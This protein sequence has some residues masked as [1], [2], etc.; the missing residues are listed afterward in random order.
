MF[1]ECRAFNMLSVE[2]VQILWFG[3]LPIF[4]PPP[5][6]DFTGFWKILTCF[7]LILSVF[8]RFHLF[9]LYLGLIHISSSFNYYLLSH[10]KLLFDPVIGI[11][12]IGNV[13]MV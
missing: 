3:W 9:L 4:V 8:D 1:I 10:I 12:N 7:S 13:K 6:P 11:V 5:S 2:N